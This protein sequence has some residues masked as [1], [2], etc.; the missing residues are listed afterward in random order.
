MA[1]QG[2]LTH[3]QQE[4]SDGMFCY[5]NLFNEFS[6]LH[7]CRLGLIWGQYETILIWL[8]K[9]VAINNNHMYIQNILLYYA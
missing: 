2:E 4:I 7:G 3:L 8:S 1:A 6:V 5:E 9:D